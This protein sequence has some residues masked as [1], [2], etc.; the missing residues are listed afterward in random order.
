[1]TTGDLYWRDTWSHRLIWFD[2]GR[3]RE[4]LSSLLRIR[5]TSSSDEQSF[6][7]TTESTAVDAI[8]D[9]DDAAAAAATDVNTSIKR[10]WQRGDVVTIYNPHTESIVTKRI[11]GVGGDA[12]RVFGEYARE[13]HHHRAAAVTA[14]A[15]VGNRGGRDTDDNGNGSN[16]DG[17]KNGDD[18][19]GVP[20]DA[21]F[22]IPFCR[23]RVQ[24]TSRNSVPQ[25]QQQQQQ[26]L[27]PPPSPSSSSS[28]N[29]GNIT[30]VVPPDH[31]WVEGDNPPQ[32]TDSRHYGPLRESSLRG[33]VVLR[34]WSNNTE[35]HRRDDGGGD[36]GPAMLGSQR[37]MPFAHRE[38]TEERMGGTNRV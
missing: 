29:H 34:L 37:P 10:P 33:R 18:C 4:Y 2:L 23:R 32:S 20:Y 9:T 26:Q 1:M 13:Y 28:S 8:T 12:V 3:W 36:D 38:S 21:R 35:R 16:I 25:Q 15:I 6:I 17:R 11:I 24:S 30:Y 27:P 7:T 22:P 19:Y 14:N 31:V 5:S